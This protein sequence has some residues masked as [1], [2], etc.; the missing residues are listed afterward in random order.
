[1]QLLISKGHS[2][3]KSLSCSLLRQVYRKVSTCNHLGNTDKI[4]YNSILKKH[5]VNMWTGFIWLGYG[6]VAVSC[7]RDN[8][9]WSSVKGEDFLDQLIDYHIVKNN[10][11][12]RS[13]VVIIC[14]KD[15]VSTGGKAVGT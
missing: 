5:G 14:R 15:P 7:K 13:S 3:W 11:A 9:P 2:V 4:I 8:E 12:S 10:S 6:P 1:M